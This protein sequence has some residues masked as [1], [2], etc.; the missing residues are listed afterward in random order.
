MKWPWQRDTTPDGTDSKDVDVLLAEA[1]SAAPVAS[2]PPVSSGPF[3]M[4]VEDVFSITGRGTVVTGKVAV[5]SLRV[6]QEVRISRGG[7]VTGTT[8]VTGIEAFRTVLDVASA[9]ESV[10]LLLARVSKADVQR[11]DVIEA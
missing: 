9:G 8:T 10:G 5:G 1:S 6:G 7:A 11:D 2:A 4:V 3:Q